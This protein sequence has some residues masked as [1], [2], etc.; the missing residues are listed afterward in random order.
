MTCPVLPKKQPER[1]MANFIAKDE[2]DI[3]NKVNEGETGRRQ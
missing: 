2:Y 1:A 3:K